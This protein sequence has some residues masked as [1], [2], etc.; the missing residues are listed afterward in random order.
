MNKSQLLL[1][2]LQKSCKLISPIPHSESERF[3]Y[4]KAAI[5]KLPAEF[6]N[7]SFLRVEDGYLREELKREDIKE[8][9]RNAKNICVQMRPAAL[10]SADAV[11]SFVENNSVYLYSGTRF[12]KQL[13]SEIKN[14]EI[15]VL[16]ANNI[17]YKGIINA[18]LP[19][20][21][22]RLTSVILNSITQKYTYALNVARDNKLQSLV[23]CVPDIDNADINLR[24]ARAILSS[25]FSHPYRRC[26]T[27][28][29]ATNKKE[30]F[31]I[32]NKLVVGQ[33]E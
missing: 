2:F 20:I 28:V 10:F 32:Y 1:E 21:N 14:R 18:V 25:V 5:K 23:L 31:E 15:V 26:I 7:E 12:K 33:A 3:E 24:V 9:S 29:I 22:S 13:E 30:T 27:I 19:P 11:F 16:K 8:V 6:I 17:Y 4:Y